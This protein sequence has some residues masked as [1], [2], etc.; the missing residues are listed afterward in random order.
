[1]HGHAIREKIGPLG[2]AAGAVQF[3]GSPP[4]AGQGRAP[5][6]LAPPGAGWAKRL[7]FML[8]LAAAS[9]GGSVKVADTKVA[10]DEAVRTGNVDYD[11]Y[12]EDVATLRGMAKKAPEDEKNARAPIVKALGLTDSSVDKVLE[13]FRSKAE[14][15]ASS[16][17]RIHFFFVGLDDQG[18]PVTGKRIQVVSIS[19]VKQPVPKDTKDLTSAMEQ[20]ALNESQ[21]MD[22]YAIVPEK[23]RRLEAKAATLRQS[24]PT[25]FPQ[26]SKDKRNQIEQ[27]LAAAQQISGQIATDC[28]KVVADAQRFLKDGAQ[29]A[30]A[31]ATTDTKEAAP[32]P[33][34]RPKGKTLRS[35]SPA[36]APLAAPV[37]PPAAPA[38][39][40][41][42][43]ARGTKPKEPPPAPKKRPPAAPAPAEPAPKAPDFNP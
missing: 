31:A 15:L 13:A 18:K 29:I 7:V 27:E 32:A 34:G 25:D 41:P 37:A 9:C 39:H 21:I 23:G 24:V 6:P 28:E 1:M 20:S 30:V 2:D 16:K 5:R 8:A 35:A 38:E 11:D 12:F 22:T 40:A 42:G 17:S 14:E 43:P 3:V 36:A 10:H 26:L 4:G 33:R 19:G